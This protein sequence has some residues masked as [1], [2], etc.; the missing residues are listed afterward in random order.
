MQCSMWQRVF[1]ELRLFICPLKIKN[2]YEFIPVSFNFASFCLMEQMSRMISSNELPAHTMHNTTAK[3][4]DLSLATKC[5]QSSP[6][7]SEYTVRFNG[8]NLFSKFI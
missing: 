5:P 8:V 7:K 3:I 1:T 6:T 4:C 2:H